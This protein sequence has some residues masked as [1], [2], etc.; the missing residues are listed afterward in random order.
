[1]GK[2]F[3]INGTTMQAVI[4]AAE[5]LLATGEINLSWKDISNVLLQEGEAVISFGSGT[6]KDR[7]IKACD[8]T[9]AGYKTVMGA[10]EIPARA[11]F[12]VTGPKN[13]LLHEVNDIRQT[14]EK[15]LRTTCEVTF[16]V[17]CDNSLNDEVRIILLATLE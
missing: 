17:A 8:D 6:G 2:G 3:T 10:T 4:D 16:G 5:G 1:M 9:I 12:R 7:A 11:L 13:L 14:I 15:A